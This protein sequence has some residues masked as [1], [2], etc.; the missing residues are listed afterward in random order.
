MNF[1]EGTVLTRF[2]SRVIIIG[3]LLY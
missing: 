1:S 3:E 2:I